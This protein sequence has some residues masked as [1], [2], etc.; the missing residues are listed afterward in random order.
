MFP[1]LKS[2]VPIL[3]HSW[4]RSR[5]HIYPAEELKHAAACTFISGSWLTWRGILVWVYD[6]ETESQGISPVC[7]LVTDWSSTQTCHL[8]SGGPLWNRE[9]AGSGPS[10]E[11]DS[12]NMSRGKPHYTPSAFIRQYWLT[13]ASL[14][15]H[16]PKQLFYYVLFYLTI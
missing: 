6:R 12:I 3:C 2:S 15:F 13:T 7:V 9:P 5:W 1:G 14:L 11:Q 4:T 16:V 10:G 8:Q